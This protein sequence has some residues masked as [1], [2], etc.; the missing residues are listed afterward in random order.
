MKMSRTCVF[1]NIFWASREARGRAA[2][3]MRRSAHVV[4]PA[5]SRARYKTVLHRVESADQLS[6]EYF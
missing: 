2:S 1:C 4:G 6:I 5:L 3:E